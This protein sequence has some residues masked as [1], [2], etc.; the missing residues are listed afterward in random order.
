MPMHERPWAPLSEITGGNAAD[1][2][3]RAKMSTNV[4]QRFGSRTTASPPVSRF[5]RNDAATPRSRPRATP[6]PG[7]TQME[8]LAGTSGYSYKEWLG[9][10]YPQ[11]L[12]VADM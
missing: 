11:K 2:A 12:R 10:F 8:L 9:H 6:V 1:R 7:M 3:H 4:Q 5:R